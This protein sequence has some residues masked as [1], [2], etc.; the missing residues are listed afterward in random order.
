MVW[1]DSIIYLH[2]R[3]REREGQQ[4]D[5]KGCKCDRDWDRRFT[6]TLAVANRY[7]PDPAAPQ[8]IVVPPG[9]TPP[10]QQGKAVRKLFKQHNW[11]AGKTF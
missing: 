6:N 1:D 4:I 5:G 10:R 2:D 3:Q 7:E 8:R 9:P 11:H